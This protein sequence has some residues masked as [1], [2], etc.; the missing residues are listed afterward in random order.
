MEDATLNILI[1]GSLEGLIW[2]G[3]VKGELGFP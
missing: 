1:N 2:D 3:G